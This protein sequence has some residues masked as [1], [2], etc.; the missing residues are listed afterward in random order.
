MNAKVSTLSALAATF[1]AAVCGARAEAQEPIR[2]G[3]DGG[4]YLGGEAG[5]TDLGSEEAYLPTTK[6]AQA[7]SSGF[8]V[9]VRLGYQFGGL[10]IEEEF[11]HASNNLERIGLHPARGARDAEIF[12]TNAL[13]DF[14][15]GWPVSPHVGAGIGAVGLHDGGQVPVLGITSFDNST[16][17]VFG[18]QAIAGISYRLAAGLTA[19]LDYRYLSTMTPHFTTSPGLVID[20]VAQGSRSISSGYSTQTILISATWHFDDR[21]PAAGR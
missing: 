10:R 3:A 4:W 6:D 5:W 2:P 13:Y 18:Y 14:D 21:A 16:S 19:E 15:L 11:R 8:A 9:G 12:M 20:G 1:A 17:W 7:W